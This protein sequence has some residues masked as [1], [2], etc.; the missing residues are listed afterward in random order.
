MVRSG[1]SQHKTLP[2]TS[3]HNR[4]DNS[5]VSFSLSLPSRSLVCTLVHS[6]SFLVPLLLFLCL[7][8]YSPLFSSILSSSCPPSPSHL[9]TDNTLF[10]SFS[11]PLPRSL[12]LYLLSFLGIALPFPPP[13]L[14][15][16]SF[17]F[18]PLI[19]SFTF[20]QLLVEQLEEQLSVTMI[21]RV[22]GLPSPSAT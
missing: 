4:L 21:P 3:A 10:A 8:V 12:S 17:A 19:V 5:S 1:R 6:P 13:I 7:F 18:P 14:Y 9:A 22:S 15:S 20:S 2:R 11:S 16:V